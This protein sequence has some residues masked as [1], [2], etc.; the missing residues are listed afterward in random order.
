MQSRCLFLR[1][2]SLILFAMLMLSLAMAPSAWA[3]TETILYNFN[4][5]SGG[6]DGY[7]PLA[8]LVADSK[9]NLYGT[10]Y[11]GGSGYGVVFELSN[12]GG[13]WTETVLHT[14][15]ANPDGAYPIGGLAFD[16]KGN[17]YGMTY[18]GGSLNYGTVYQLTK[19]GSSWNETVIHNFASSSGKDGANPQYGGLT[20][21]SKGNM[22]G[23]TYAGGSHGVG[24]AFIMTP[25]GKTWKE[26]IIH[27][28]AGGSDG[29]YPFGNIIV[30]KNGYFYG[31]TQYGGPTYN[32]GTVYSLFTARGVWVHKS[33]Y[34]FQGGG[35]GIYPLAG[36]VMDSAGNLYGTTYQGGASNYGTAYELKAGKNN[37]FSW[38]LLYSFK[39]G[40]TDGAYPYYTGLILD[41][42]NNLYGVNYNGGSSSNYG[43][44]YELKLSSGKYKEV[45]VH[46]FAGGSTDGCESRS[47]VM[48]YKGSLYG[49][50]YV[51][52]SHGAGV[53]FS[54]K[55]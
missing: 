18:Q 47:N 50:T 23:V 28:F 54:L 38:K 19:S 30:G 5:V 53:A 16:S 12:S 31:T 3:S 42:K 45:I 46:A 39:G 44:V 2:G 33:V 51:C 22:Y 21:D 20:F 10:T 15:T 6:T 25:S 35:G 1:A 14:F 13:T 17:L 8:P 29:A 48:L 40:N 4:S 32:A 27:N 36:V 26:K 37:K 11:V 41:S 24:T 55:P 9:G 49:T 43:T 52:G 7:Y 34:A